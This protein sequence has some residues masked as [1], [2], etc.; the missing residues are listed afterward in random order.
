MPSIPPSVLNPCGEAGEILTARP[1]VETLFATPNTMLLFAA[2][3]TV[4][5]KAI[6]CGTE[7]GKSLQPLSPRYGAYRSIGK[8]FDH[9]RR[10]LERLHTIRAPVK[11]EA[12]ETGLEV[13]RT[14]STVR[15]PGTTDVSLQHTSD[16]LSPLAVTRQRHVPRG[17]SQS[18]SGPQSQRAWPGTRGATSLGQPSRCVSRTRSRWS[19]N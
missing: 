8:A 6:C 14:V 4:S 9:A 19:V 5:S 16:N 3:S 17:S 18:R 13:Q 10:L 12:D 1:G 7:R 11:R 15:Q 2:S